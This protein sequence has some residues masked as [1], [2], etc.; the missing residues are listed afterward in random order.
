MTLQP[1]S[2][3]YDSKTQG[4]KDLLEAI[5]PGA[6]KAIEERRCVWCRKPVGLFRDQLSV[7]E[8]GI[9]GLCQVCQDKAFG[10]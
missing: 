3:P 8:H 6:L 1:H 2:D 10:G 5:N 7:R 9:S 4:M